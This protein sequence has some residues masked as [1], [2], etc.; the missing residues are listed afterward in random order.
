MLSLRKAVK[1]VRSRGL[2]SLATPLRPLALL[3]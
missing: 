2:E 3:F 1:A